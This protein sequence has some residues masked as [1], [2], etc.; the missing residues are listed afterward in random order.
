M[1]QTATFGEPPFDPDDVSEMFSE[2]AEYDDG[3]FERDANEPANAD[4]SQNLD[5]SNL[6]GDELQSEANF[7]DSSS[8]GAN[9]NAQNATPNLATKTQADPKAAKTQAVLKEAKRLFGEPEVL[10]I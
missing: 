6:S 3:L 7:D 5:T 10:E 8:S 2:A 4:A 1:P 9:L